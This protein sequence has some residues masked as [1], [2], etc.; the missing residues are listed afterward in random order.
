MELEEKYE[1][2]LIEIHESKN[3]R[4]ENSFVEQKTKFNRA[5]LKDEINYLIE[6]D[7]VEFDKSD[8]AY[9]LTYE[10]YEEVEEIRFLRRTGEEFTELEYQHLLKQSRIKKIKTLLIGVVLFSFA[11]LAYIGIG[12]TKKNEITPEIANQIEYAISSKM[13]SILNQQTIIQINKA[14][15]WSGIT[16]KEIINVNQFGNVVFSDTKD[17]IYRI[18]PEELSI[19]KV[20]SN[21]H[22]FEIIKTEENYI[23]DWEMKRLVAIAKSEVGEL[24]KFEKYCLKIP[25]VISSN[26]SKENIGKISFKELISISGDLAFQIKDLKEGQKVNL[27]I[28]D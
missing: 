19:E 21:L 18:R 24:N 20:A 23:L 25:A 14:W 11:A 28:I 12:P 15:K 4:F 9:Y 2:L 5:T 1:N 7:L 8:N 3:E 10:G 17:T 26:Y 6:A 27:R 16:A 13:D 22:Q